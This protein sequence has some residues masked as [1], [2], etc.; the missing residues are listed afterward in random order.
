MPA[1]VKWYASVVVQMLNDTRKP[2]GWL[3]LHV[4]AR[5]HLQVLVKFAA[6]TM[7]LAGTQNGGRDAWC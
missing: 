5:E 7:G 3:S 4:A 1:M 6:G 2:K